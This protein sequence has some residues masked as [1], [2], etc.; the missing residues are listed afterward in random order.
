MLFIISFYLLK[1]DCSFRFCD[2]APLKMSTTCFRDGALEITGVAGGG[3]FLMH[4][5]FLKARLSAR[6][7]S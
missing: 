6:I 2:T 3:K 7:F 4:D 1:F 5:F